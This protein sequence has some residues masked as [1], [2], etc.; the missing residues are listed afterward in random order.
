[1][2]LVRSKNWSASVLLPWS[3]WAMMEKS[4]IRRVSV[5]MRW[6]LFRTGESIGSPARKAWAPGFIGEY[7]GVRELRIDGTRLRP[8]P[9]WHQEQELMLGE[10]LIPGFSAA[11]CCLPDTCDW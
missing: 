7:T 2:V 5:L 10:P 8:I 9:P 1:M 6:L 11:S 4:R 3:I